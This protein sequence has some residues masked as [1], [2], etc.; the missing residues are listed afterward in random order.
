[1]RVELPFLHALAWLPPVFAVGALTFLLPH[2]D[3]SIRTV[4]G[5]IILGAAT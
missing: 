5:G 3:I 4:I 2:F 1:V